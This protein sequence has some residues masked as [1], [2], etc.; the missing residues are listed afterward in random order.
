MLVAEVKMKTQDAI[1]QCDCAA[2]NND[3]IAEDTQRA[4]DNARALVPAAGTASGRQL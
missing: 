3:L 2:I 4:V 1:S